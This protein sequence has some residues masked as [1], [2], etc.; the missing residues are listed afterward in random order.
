MPEPLASV[1]RRLLSESALGDLWKAECDAG[2]W[3]A[4]QLDTDERVPATT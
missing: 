1:L 4:F 2:G 3:E